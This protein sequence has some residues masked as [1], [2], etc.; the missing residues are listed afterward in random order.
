[1]TFAALASRHATDEE[2]DHGNVFVVPKANCTKRTVAHH[3][4]IRNYV[5][6]SGRASEILGPKAGVS[7][8]TWNENHHG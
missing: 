3:P 7:L 8:I 4:G 5:S 6:A 1:M 2:E